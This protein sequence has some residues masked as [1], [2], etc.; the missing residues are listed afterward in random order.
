MNKM[1]F[2]GNDTIDCY[3]LGTGEIKKILAVS[4]QKFKKIQ[5][6]F[7]SFLKGVRG[8]FDARSSPLEA[9]KG[10]FLKPQRPSEAIIERCVVQD[11]SKRFRNYAPTNAI[12]C[13]TSD[14]RRWVRVKEWFDQYDPEDKKQK[15]LKEILIQ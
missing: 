12:Y 14:Y 13:N 5:K 1:I 15:F 8:R 7:Q 3:P 9:N 10:E 11:M 6:E 2:F 4:E